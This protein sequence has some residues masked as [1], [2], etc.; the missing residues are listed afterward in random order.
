M[1]LLRGDLDKAEEE[2]EFARGIK[3][4]YSKGLNN[5]GLVY[6]KKG[7]IEKAK[8]LYYEAL[9]QDFPYSGAIDNLI[10]LYLSQKDKIHAKRW[11]MYLYPNNE[12]EVDAL[13]E[14]YL[15][16]NKK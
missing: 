13:I 6:F 11:L 1:Y 10:L 2:L 15:I 5:L 4:I 3:P 9:R 16:E 12:K 8:E 7:E 14:N